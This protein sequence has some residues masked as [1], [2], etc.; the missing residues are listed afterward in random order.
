MPEGVRR[1]LVDRASKTPRNGL[2]VVMYPNTYY[3]FAI[4]GDRRDLDERDRSFD[5]EWILLLHPALGLSSGLVLAKWQ[6][7]CIKTWTFVLCWLAQAGRPCDCLRRA[8]LCMRHGNLLL[9][10][11]SAA[12]PL[13][14]R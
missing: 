11:C 7:T 12:I 9:S 2:E 13:P 5:P 10:S 4:R 3:G 6:M 8:F 14:P 1:A